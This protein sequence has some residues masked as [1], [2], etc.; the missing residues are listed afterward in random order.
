MDIFSYATDA[1]AR[2][3]S[4]NRMKFNDLFWWAGLLQRDD[5]YRAI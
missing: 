5:L 3:L 2:R 1:V 4:G